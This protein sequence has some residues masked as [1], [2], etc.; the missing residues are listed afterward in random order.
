MPYDLGVSNLLSQVGDRSS[1]FEVPSVRAVQSRHN[2]DLP[3]N[4]HRF[5]TSENHTHI[6]G[7]T[8]ILE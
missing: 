5:K 7:C 4:I 6:A 3:R 2:L 8:T 1:A